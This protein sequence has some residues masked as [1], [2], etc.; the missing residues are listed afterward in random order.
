MAYSDPTTRSTND[1]IT[2]AIW[3]ADLVDNIIALHE[4]M[5]S[6]RVYHDTTQALTGST[7]TALAFNQELYD[8]A[9]IHDTSSNNSRLTCPSGGDGIYMIVGNVEWTTSTGTYYLKIRLNG[10]TIIANQRQDGTA[11]NP[12]QI[13]TL[14]VLAAGDYVELVANPS[15]NRTVASTA[16]YSPR[17]MMHRVG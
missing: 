4:S 3:N 6:A 11:N 9:A 16:A 13:S 10:S 7:D 5:P 12:G 1:S 15:G 14:Y 8:N 17:F 2:A